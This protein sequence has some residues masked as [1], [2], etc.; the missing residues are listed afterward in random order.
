M[1]TEDESM[2]RTLNL[3]L[4]G[5]GGQGVVTLAGLICEAAM[6]QALPALSYVTKGMAQR[7]GTVSVQLR[8]GVADACPA[9]SPATADIVVA[10][11]AAEA[12]R[13][14]GYLRRGGECLYSAERVLPTST[15]LGHDAYPD[16]APLQAA[17][18][19]LEG[20]WRRLNPRDMPRGTRANLCML[21]LLA[22]TGL[23]SMLDEGCLLQTLREKWPAHAD[24]NEAAFL[25]GAAL[26]G[27]E[28]ACV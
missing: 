19:A 5:I 15:Q 24:E 25:A 6:R 7:G 11:E 20:R 26:S 14:L 9:L 21:G 23:R 8:L 27:K 18:A 12:Y 28:T 17:V 4:A 2:N 16:E 13:A 22:N 1:K 10:M 3:Y